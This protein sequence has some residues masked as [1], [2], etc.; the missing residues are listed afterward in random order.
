MK[1]VSFYLENSLH[2]WNKLWDR[3]PN[4]TLQD[5]ACA[6]PSPLVGKIQ[7]KSQTLR[8]AL[9]EALRENFREALRV[10]VLHQWSPL[11]VQVGQP[12]SHALHDIWDHWKSFLQFDSW[13]HY[14]ITYIHSLKSYCINTTLYIIIHLSY[15]YHLLSFL[16]IFWGH[17]WIMLN[18][19]SFP[20]PSTLRT[21]RECPRKIRH[22]GLSLLGFLLR[23]GL[24]SMTCYAGC[25]CRMTMG[26]DKHGTQHFRSWVYMPALL[27]LQL[28]NPLKPSWN[29]CRQ[30]KEW[31]RIVKETMVIPCSSHKF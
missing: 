28:W 4:P 14:G 5:T 8:E 17:G 24:T 19:Q 23:S 30:A 12:R 3:Y 25:R 1:I 11:P 7:G 22:L 31:M 29:H 26:N 18:T 15:T 6:L 16:I 2:A 9:R 13:E 20:K 21:E 27:K 10:Q